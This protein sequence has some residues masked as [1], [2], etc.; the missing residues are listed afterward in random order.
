MKETDFAL[1]FSLGGGL[2]TAGRICRS[3][4]TCELFMRSLKVLNGAE[5]DRVSAF[6]GVES[7]TLAVHAFVFAVARVPD[8]GKAFLAYVDD[9]TL[10]PKAFP[11]ESETHAK[12]AEQKL[13]DFFA[14]KGLV[15]FYEALE[16]AE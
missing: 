4:K 1:D 5:L 7:K 14:S 3:V 15:D 9:E 11:M 8:S 6:V 13:R 10:S 16:N 2:A 12:Q